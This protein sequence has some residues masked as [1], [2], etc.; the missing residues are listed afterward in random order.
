MAK[1]LIPE[2]RRQLANVEYIERDGF[3][4]L[5]RLGAL[6]NDAGDTREVQELVLRALE[7]RDRFGPAAEVLDALVRKQGLYPYL[8]P[9]NLGFMDMIAYEAHRPENLDDVVFHRVQ[10]RVYRLLM[11]GHNIVLSAPTSFGKS[12]VIDAVAASGRFRNIVVVV[13]TIA[14]IDETRRRLF[15]RF[16][17]THKIITHP[18]QK[19]GDRNI[20]VLTQERVVEFPDF[21]HVDFFVIDEFYKLDPRRDADRSLLLN[22]A[23]YRL[24]SPTNHF[25]LLGPNIQGISEQFPQR[26]QCTFIRTDYATVA[27]ETRRIHATK[28]NRLERLVDLCR[29]LDEPTLIY[30]SS[31]G[32][33]RNVASALLQAGVGGANAELNAAV[34]W[35]GREYHPR[36][37]FT[38]ALRQA[39]GIHHGRIPR[40]LS[41]F[42]VRAFN[43]GALRFLVCT[44]TLI[45]GVNTKAKNVIVYDHKISTR[46]LD[47]FTFNNIIGRSG[48]MFQHF[49]GRVFLFG[50]PPQEEFP[51]VDIPLVDQEDVSD[52]LLIQLDD[53][54]LTDESRKR[55][56]R[57]RNQ[58]VLPMEVLR[59]NR[60]IEPL[61]QINLAQ[62]LRRHLNRYYPLLTWSGL[63]T[64]DEL[65]AVCRLIWTYLVPGNQR[66]GGVQSGDQLAFKVNRFRS[67]PRI[68]ALITSA[69][70]ESRADP[71]AAVEDSL[72]F[73]RHWADF[74]FPRYL[75]A[76]SRIQETVFGAVGRRAG[77]YSVFATQVE[78]HFAPAGIAALDEYGVPLQVGRRL[79]PLLG[80]GETLDDALAGL[81]G[82]SL[83]RVDLQ[84]FERRLVEE[85]QAY[86]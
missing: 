80:G 1:P 16:R 14:L 43:D 39:I 75:M 12:L 29:T 19:R 46:N 37:T 57:L 27:S 28:A 72:E 42:A 5:A 4:L 26:F 40:S 70:Q 11:D 3:G 61:A 7:Q 69:L 60:G 53:N 82:L 21:G 34:E 76:V 64:Y 86:I 25:Y 17:A 44:S 62:E 49:V 6:V 73:L 52:S 23:F 15:E 77:D 79:A 71:D 10:A 68:R 35:I 65:R 67:N 66:R 33:A 51:M 30:C 50:E 41:Q 32:S 56:Q 83:D 8:D 55:M 31:P 22:Q 48:R 18:S 85:A 84:P 74:A 45:E 81:R 13:P 63:P 59:A 58:N 24:Y 20:Y 36:W 47:F 54:D 9:E 78:N 2:V 38:Q